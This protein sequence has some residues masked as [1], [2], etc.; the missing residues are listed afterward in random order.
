MVKAHLN[1]T[2][3]AFHRND[4]REYAL[5]STVSLLMKLVAVAEGIINCIDKALRS[6][7]PKFPQ[8]L[9]NEY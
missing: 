8:V 2:E 3:I 1:L 7:F 4:N 5:Y 9:S 6:L